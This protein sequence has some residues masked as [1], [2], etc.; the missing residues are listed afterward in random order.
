[1]PLL[2]DIVSTGGTASEPA[3]ASISWRVLKGLEFI[4]NMRQIHRDIKPANLLINRS[5]E[6]KVADFGVIREMDE[7]KDFAATFVGTF[8][9]MSPGM[10]RF[11]CANVNI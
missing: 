8:S 11:M 9:Y 10:F 5:G 4:H 2:Q 3:L 1:M 6:V 7:T